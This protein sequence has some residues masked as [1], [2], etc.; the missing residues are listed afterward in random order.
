ML[1]TP[2]PVTGI[3]HISSV[4][5]A[6]MTDKSKK[7][8]E[9]RRELLNA[10][11]VAIPSNRD[12]VILASKAANALKD[13]FSDATE[14]EVPEEVKAAV[15]ETLGVKA[16][17]AVAEH[18]CSSTDC[19]GEKSADKPT[20]KIYVDVVPRIDIKAFEQVIKAAATASGVGGDG[21]LVQAIH[22]ASSHLGAACPVIEVE[23]DP[24]TG[25][26][27]G[28]NKST[29]AGEESLVEVEADEKSA[30]EK[31]LDQVL[32][33]EES[34]AEAAAASDEEP[35]PAV[36]AADEKAKRRR[37]LQLMQMRALTQS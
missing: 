4:S 31:A 10:G 28:A 30:F 15:L 35:A 21:A 20:G 6:F 25:A 1:C 17:E 7:D 34:P 2:D 5:V 12:A 9:Q 16:P 32:T 27:D 18:M 14:G 24:G 33:P 19:C 8:G 11:I 37:A 3:R 23:P 22:D 13:A 36:E 29:E 26:S